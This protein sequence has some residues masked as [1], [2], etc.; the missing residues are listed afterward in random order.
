MKIRNQDKA[1]VDAKKITEGLN[2]NFGKG[3]TSPYTQIS[4][5]LYK[6]D[7]GITQSRVYISDT[8]DVLDDGLCKCQ[9]CYSFIIPTIHDD[10]LI[11]YNLDNGKHH[12]IAKQKDNDYFHRGCRRKGTEWRCNF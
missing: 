11:F 8:Y 2:K 5:E 12:Y 10:K 1:Y 3:Y 9:R 4:R 6:D 7:E